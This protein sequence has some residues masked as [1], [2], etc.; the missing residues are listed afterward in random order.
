MSSLQSWL[1]AGKADNDTK[2]D[3]KFIQEIGANT[4]RVAHYQQPEYF[5]ELL[6]S[7]GLVVWAENALVDDIGNSEAFKQNTYIQMEELVLQN[8]NHPSI[9]MW[10]LANELGLRSKRDPN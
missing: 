4:V 5:Y 10:S 1:A 9:V 7:M 6:D 8:Y 3:A 2:A